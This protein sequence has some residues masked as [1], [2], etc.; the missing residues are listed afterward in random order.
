MYPQ[1]CGGSSPFD[2]TKSST[3]P[4]RLCVPSCQS[5]QSGLASS[6]CDGALYSIVGFEP[7]LLRSRPSSPALLPIVH[8]EPLQFSCE[9][10]A[11]LCASGLRA[12]ILHSIYPELPEPRRAGPIAFVDRLSDF[13]VLPQRTQHLS[14]DSTLI[15]PRMGLYTELCPAS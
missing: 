12:K 10:P 4:S 15:P 13:S 1:G 6:L 5:R 3:V 11:T 2:G 14:L 8:V 7:R 9:P